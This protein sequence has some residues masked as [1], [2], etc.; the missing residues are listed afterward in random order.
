MVSETLEPLRDMANGVAPTELE[1]ERDVFED[2]PRHVAGLQEPKDVVDEAR[3]RAGQALRQAGL[4]EIL[5]RE[6]S[7]DQVDRLRKTTER[8]DILVKSRVRE[9]VA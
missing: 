5:A 9:P 2:H 8:R 7:D 1:H 3:L 4:R 6:P